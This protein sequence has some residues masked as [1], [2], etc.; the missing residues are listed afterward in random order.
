MNFID[1]GSDLMVNLDNVTG[2]ERNGHGSRIFIGLAGEAVESEVDYD[3]LRSIIISRN[4][5]M[6]SSSQ[7]ARDIRQIAKNQTTPVP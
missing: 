7:M 5:R 2:I 6:Q 4:N 1:V 3:A